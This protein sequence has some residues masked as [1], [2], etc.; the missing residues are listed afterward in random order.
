MW[1]E[2]DPTSP[3]DDSPQQQC[4]LHEAIQGPERCPAVRVSLAHGC[5]QSPPVVL[6]MGLDL[7]LLGAVLHCRLALH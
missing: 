6:N 7:T 1:C 2:A 4:P 3:P 5:H